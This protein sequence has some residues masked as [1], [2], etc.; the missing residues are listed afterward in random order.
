MFR[1][2]TLF[3]IGAGASKEV[4]LP[5]GSELREK[6]V[7]LVDVHL[8]AGSVNRGD[9]E[10]YR[11]AQS[12]FSPQSNGCL[13]AGR[14][15]SSGIY[16]KRSI[17]EYLDWCAS[18]KIAVGYG[19]A[20]IVRAILSEEAKA[21]KAYFGGGDDFALQNMQNKWFYELL[22][23]L[24]Q[25]RRKEEV[26]QLFDNVKFLI[27]NYDRCLEYFLYLAIQRMD[28]QEEIAREIISASGT[29]YHAYGAIAPLFGPSSL[30]LALFRL[31]VVRCCS[32]VVHRRQGRHESAGLPDTCGAVG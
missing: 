19:K 16:G 17:D 30:A 21:N 22:Q 24:T 12:A 11:Q 3:I 7:N 25:G 4:G 29:F 23:M 2:S 28:V 27:F 20:A 10:L 31:S 13:L 6:I 18:D 32:P 5:V 8:Q 26:K 15:I 9:A 14:R 1:R